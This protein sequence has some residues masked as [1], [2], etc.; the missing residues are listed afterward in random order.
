MSLHPGTHSFFFW[1]HRI[2]VEQQKFQLDAEKNL[3]CMQ[4]NF[5][6]YKSQKTSQRHISQRNW[7][8]PFLTTIEFIKFQGKLLFSFF[9]VEWFDFVNDY[10]QHEQLSSCDWIPTCCVTWSELFIGRDK[11]ISSIGLFIVS[12]MTE[13]STV[14][15]NFC[16]VRPCS[17]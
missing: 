12:E 17:C 14:I 3:M 1:T 13:N 5:I 7:T 2:Y 16:L 15:L 4:N 9:V 6:N 10:V 8:F 11:Q